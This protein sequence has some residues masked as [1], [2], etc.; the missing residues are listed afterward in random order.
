MTIFS[1]SQS[2]NTTDSQSRN[3][4]IT[5]IQSLNITDAIPTLLQRN[6]NVSAGAVDSLK[7][8]IG[9]HYGEI[10]EGL[11]EIK[12]YL[13]KY[14]YIPQSTK[15]FT[16][17]F[18]KALV[19]AITTYQKFYHLEQTG[20]LDANTIGQMILPRCGNPDVGNQSTFLKPDDKSARRLRSVGRYNIIAGNP[21]WEKTDLTYAFLPENNLDESYKKAIRRAF[22]TWQAVTKLTFRKTEFYDSADIKIGFYSGDHG[23]GHAFDGQLGEL[24]HAYPP[25]VGWFHFDKDE[26]W[27]VEGVGEQQTMFD[28]NFDE[29]T[30][31]DLESVAVHEIGHLLGLDHSSDPKAIMFPTLIIGTKRVQL[32]KDDID[33]IQSIYGAN[34]GYLH[35]S[36]SSSND[37]RRRFGGWAA[38][39]QCWG[40]LLILVVIVLDVYITN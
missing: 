15:N 7:R 32:Q 35:G 22:N 4:N 13:Q 2:Q 28:M 19:N 23:C 10:I 34:P 37:V 11:T 16:N 24:A 17:D 30:L 27:D 6:L 31:T 8:F 12:T 25:P 1:L 40:I 5:D 29:T 14:G 38:V 18:D 21:K 3:I 9:T 39:R 33:G 20:E 26:N 36:D